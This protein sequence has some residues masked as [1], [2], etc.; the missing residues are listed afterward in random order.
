MKPIRFGSV[1]SGIEAAS[2]AWT[3]LGWE[4]AW[5]AEIE[6]FPSRVLAHRYPGVVNL[7]D[8]TTIE[9]RLLAGE[10]ERPQILCG[11][12]PCQSFSVAGKR[13]SMD[14]ERGNLTLRFVELANAIGPDV[15]FWEN[16]PGVLSTS[17]NAFGCF[18]GALV[19]ADAALVPGREQRWTDAGLVA[20]PKRTAAWRVLDAQYFGLAQRRRRVFV[21]A[22][23][24]TSGIDPSE[25][26]FEPEGVSR[27]S[28]SG[29]K[30]REDAA[31]T[32]A[33]RT[34][35]GGG[36]GADFDLDGGLRVAHSLRADGFDAS[37]DG[38]GRGTPLI[39][40]ISPALKARDYK[41]P[42][43]D[44]DGDGDGAALVPVLAFDLN[45]VT[46]RANRSNP[47]PGAPCHAI[48]ASSIPPSIA[49]ALQAGTARENPDSGPDGAGV[50]EELAYTLE[51]R[52]EVQMVAT[53]AIAFPI[54]QDPDASNEMM[55]PLGATH[56]AAGAGVFSGAGVR[57]LM[58][59]ECERLQG[60]PDDHTA[61]PGAADGPRYKAIGNSW[62]VAVVRWIGIRIDAA[63]RRAA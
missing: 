19:G 5:F 25:I 53:P 2:L 34:R 41:G 31:G 29:R 57:R 52:S 6:K 60:M 61:I 42:S 62:A 13:G 43:S 18:L 3:S 17:D 4:P 24:R 30:A 54:L 14:D 49:Y 58:P 45:Q 26:L 23:P 11:G 20:G 32:L 51:S 16:V 63:M 15:V 1:C 10:V 44:G 55:Q 39:P 9:A 12:T 35:G 50:S 28:S 40:A 38:T 33:A 36:L 22:S 37:E 59:V 27:N 56:S 21:V 8:M 7:G 46:S 48:P 47:R